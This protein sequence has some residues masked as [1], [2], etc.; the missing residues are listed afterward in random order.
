MTHT[1]GPQ[2]DAHDW[3]TLSPRLLRL[4]RALCGGGNEQDAQD[5]AQETVARLL[6]RAEPPVYAYAR[7]TLIRVWIDDHRRRGR[8]FARA[9]RWAFGRPDAAPPD[10]APARD[11]RVA[12]VR[13]SLARLSP[14]QRA[15]IVMRTVEDM[16]PRE[17]AIALGT[18]EQTVRAC[19]HAARKRVRS[20]LGDPS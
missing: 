3:A 12:A 18:N 17:I 13:R 4:A 9:M 20:A 6:T 15:A 14:Q 10:D 2:P 1:H 16:S 8:A 19:L 7:R 11:E 5:L